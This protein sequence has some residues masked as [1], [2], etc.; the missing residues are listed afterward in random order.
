MIFDLDGTLVQTE[1][2]KALSYARAAVELCPDDLREGDVVE[3]FKEVVGLSRQ[4]V[5]LAL[6]ER[7]GLE[8]AA[9]TRLS[10]FGVSAPWQAFVQVRLRIYEEMLADPE[11]LR[12][13]QWPHNVA[14]L[15]EAQRSGCKTAL[16]TMSRCDQA[17]RVLDVLGFMEAFDFVATRDDVEHGKPDP[18]IYD[19]VSRELGIP[20]E[21]SLVIEDSPAGVQAALAAGMSVVA[22]STPFT[23]RRLR[24]A[25]LLPPGHIVDDPAALP[26]VVEHVIAHHRSK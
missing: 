26:G 25:A 23:R 15:H 1:R 18:E 4:E 10:E 22:V 6:V 16:A 21:E 11:V 5:A 19:L 8:E 7:F 3:A 13:N 9:R 14:L 2:L 24:E 17:Q 12:S 20:P